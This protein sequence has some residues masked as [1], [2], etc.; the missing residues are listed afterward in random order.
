ME[1]WSGDGAAKDCNGFSVLSF[2]FCVPAVIGACFYLLR[3]MRSLSRFGGGGG[4]FGIHPLVRRH[5]FYEGFGDCILFLYYRLGA[6]LGS[7]GCICVRFGDGILGSQSASQS[8]EISLFLRARVCVCL[9]QCLR[10]PIF[11]WALVCPKSV[12]LTRRA[13]SS[14][15]MDCDQY[16]LPLDCFVVATDSQIVRHVFW[17]PVHYFPSASEIFELDEFCL[18]IPCTNF[19]QFSLAFCREG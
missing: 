9:C 8:W 6:W 12:F 2:A 14:S 1:D 17:W 19:H 7:H 5:L 13:H 15:T 10:L 16:L 18:S 11:C 4:L 3:F